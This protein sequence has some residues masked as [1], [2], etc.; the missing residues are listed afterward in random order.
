MAAETVQHRRLSCIPG[1]K[2]KAGQRKQDSQVKMYGN[3]LGWLVTQ[4][5]EIPYL[6]ADTSVPI[7]GVVFAARS[8]RIPGP[9]SKMHKLSAAFAL[10][11]SRLPWDHTSS[12]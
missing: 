11:L 4:K 10:R 3:E 7:T 1:G 2:Q 5:Q 9:T 12:D 6:N 8:P